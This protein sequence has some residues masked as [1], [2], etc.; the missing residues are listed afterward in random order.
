M[1]D[2]QGVITLGLGP[3]TG[4]DIEHFVLVGL[5]ANPVA[6]VVPTVSRSM[7]LDSNPSDT[8]SLNSNPSD[9]ITLDS[10]PSDALAVNS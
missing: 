6:A 3:T 9:T 7:T 2:I 5:N 10:N 1:A 8:V 4:S